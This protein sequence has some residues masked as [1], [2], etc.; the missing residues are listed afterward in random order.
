MA[1][2]ADSRKGVPFLAFVDTAAHL[3]QI[4]PKLQFW[5]PE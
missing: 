5:G 2:D 1:H 3:G 4:A